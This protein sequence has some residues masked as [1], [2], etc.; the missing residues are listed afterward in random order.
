[1]RLVAGFEQVEIDGVGH[2]RVAGVA[3]MQM[4][5]G[6]ERGEELFRLVGIPR[7]TIEIDHGIVGVAR[8]DPFSIMFT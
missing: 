8:A 3:R 7:H 6:I 4:V 1:M 5:A 2:R